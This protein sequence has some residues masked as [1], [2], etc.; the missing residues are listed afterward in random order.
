MSKLAGLY[1]STRI[2]IMIAFVV[3]VTMLGI[4]CAASTGLPIVWDNAYLGATLIFWLIM[5]SNG[6]N[7][8]TDEKI[9][10]EAM[11]AGSKKSRSY[12]I[13]N[14]ANGL[15][16]GEL[17]SAVVLSGFVFGFL[18]LMLA[19]RAG[20]PVLWFALFGL[21][22]SLE[23]NLPPLKLA[24]RPFPELTMLL[25]SAVVAVIGIQYV[26][27]SRVTDLGI[28]MGIAFGLFSGSWFVCQSIIDYDVDKAARKVTTAVYVGP[29]AAVMI[30]CV[31]P[32]T[33]VVVMVSHR[34]ASDSY[35]MVYP[36]HF[37]GLCAV[38]LATLIAFCGLDAHKMWQRAMLVTFIFG[39]A[40]ALMVLFG[41]WSG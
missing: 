26:L 16:R 24:Y 4:A 21:F 3:P 9:D 37:A 13:L 2:G 15:T 33:A 25:P 31:Y 17:L 11:K 5:M 38:A 30:A 36:L 19:S 1:K 28:V 20:H 41:V 27:V 23:Y 35:L 18:L 12:N 39:V 34:I 6:L 32:I 10:I 40:W 14:V 29:L 7:N 22:M 8:L